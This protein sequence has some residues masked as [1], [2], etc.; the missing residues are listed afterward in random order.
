MKCK[1][2]FILLIAVLFNL[3]C[4]IKFNNVIPLT[5]KDRIMPNGEPKRIRIYLNEQ[6]YTVVFGGDYYKN[7]KSKT[8]NY[9]KNED[10]YILFNTKNEMSD[11]TPNSFY[12]NIGS[13]NHLGIRIEFR[14]LP[15][16]LQKMV[17]ED[18]MVKWSLSN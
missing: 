2:I 18:Y 12:P 15:E 1:K 7:V 9:I 17:I 6:S 10:G 5:L 16:Y 8:N 3:G 4:A 11:I 14:T 13:T